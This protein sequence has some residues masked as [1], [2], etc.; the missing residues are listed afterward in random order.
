MSLV[1]QKIKTEGVVFRGMESSRRC[2]SRESIAGI[3]HY[4]HML[5]WQ[6]SLASHTS[7]RN[8]ASAE[9]SVYFQ[10]AGIILDLRDKGER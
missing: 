10:Q 6:K 1:A 7:V 4:I 9:N 2:K 5:R 3:I 8:L